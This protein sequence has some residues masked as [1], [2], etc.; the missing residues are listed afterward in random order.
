MK[1]LNVA[2][3]EL[4]ENLT[5]AQHEQWEHCKERGSYY[6]VDCRSKI[7]KDCII[8]DASGGEISVGFHQCR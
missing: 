8:R 4:C 3:K 6:G 1:E 5:N 7:S 2:V